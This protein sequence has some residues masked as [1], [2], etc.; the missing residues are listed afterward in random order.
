MWIATTVWLTSGVGPCL[1]SES[2]NQGQSRMSQ[3]ELLSL[4]VGPN[5][6]FLEL[7]LFWL[8]WWSLCF[9]FDA[10]LLEVMHS[11]VYLLE[12]RGR[13]RI[14]P[15][16]KLKGNVVGIF[17]RLFCATS[18]LRYEAETRAAVGQTEVKVGLRTSPLFQRLLNS[19]LVF[20]CLFSP[21][22]TKI[23]FQERLT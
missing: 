1:G 2:M 15:H 23:S 12:S 20:V 16:G 22:S 7:L 4:G 6:L 8:L 9:C 17:T 18:R 3:S 13:E 11:Q 14:N 21:P 10:S 5:F 19:P